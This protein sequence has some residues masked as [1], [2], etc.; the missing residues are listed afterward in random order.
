M[1]VAPAQFL[2][3]LCRELA[4]HWRPGTP[5]L[6]CAKGI[7]Q[8]SGELMSEVVAVEL[9][10]AR[11]AVLSGPTF[12]AEV[13]KGLPAAVTLACEDD[14]LG[15]ALVEA[16]GS[17]HF[18]PYLS[19]DIVGAQ[20][21]GAV[22]NV[23]AIACG[24]VSGRRLGDNAR[25]ALITRGLAEMIRLALA[26]GA[27]RETLMGLSGLG[28]LVLTCSSEQSRNM[29]LGLELGRGARLT[30]I[31]AERRSVAEGVASAPAVLALAGRLGVE[32]PIAAAVDAILH[33]DASVDEAIAGL[34]S[35]PFKGEW[36]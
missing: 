33:H 34:L 15:A 31:L 29:S 14:A 6:I 12:A 24:I 36:D 30:D 4:A 20:I 26:K 11:L 28:D 3:P 21:G 35:R 9:S 8:H 1:L 32:M 25:A 16:L 19:P 23:L 13:A 17:P 22:K 27:S 5:A 7:E 18:R 2:R 10:G